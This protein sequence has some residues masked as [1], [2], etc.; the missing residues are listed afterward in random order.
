[1][2]TILY[3]IRHAEAEGNK[4]RIF[5]GITDSSLTP[6]GINQ[7]KKVAR[8]LSKYGIKKIYS[9]DLKRAYDTA[10]EFSDITGIDINTS[11]QLR[12]IDGGLWENMPWSELAE[13][14]PDEFYSWEKS[15]HKHKM[16]QGES[17]TDLRIRAWKI[18]D[19]IAYENRGNTVAIFTHG[20]VIKVLIGLI[21]K[22]DF[23]ELKNIKWHEN[24]S[25][26]KVIYEND[27][28]EIKFEGNYD[29]LDSSEATILNQGWAN[30]KES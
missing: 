21:N 10:K 29:H 18:L 12:E 2:S 11:E 17:I 20:T 7:A 1:M 25:V 14:Y 13:K 8:S 16:P 28:F 19:K 24:T 9:S 5:H 27:D 30:E 26:T 6:N 22:I 23:A 3:I 4:Y 15:P